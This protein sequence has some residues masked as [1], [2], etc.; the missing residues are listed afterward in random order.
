MRSPADSLGYFAS[1]SC[2]LLCLYLKNGGNDA[3][4]QSSLLPALLQSLQ[5]H[6][7]CMPSNNSDGTCQ[8]GSKEVM[9]FLLLALEA[10]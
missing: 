3:S 6:A 2:Q 4:F 10:K 8:N 9:E 1:L 5:N 7:S